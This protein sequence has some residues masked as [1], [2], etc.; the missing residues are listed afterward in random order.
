MRLHRLISKTDGLRTLFQRR[1][2]AQRL[3]VPR[4]ISLELTNACNAQCIMCPREK[5]TRRIRLIDISLVEKIAG[6]LREQKLHKLNLFWFGE[7]L[8]HPQ[9]VD[10]MRFLRKTLPSTKINLSTNGQLLTGTLAMGV[11]TSGIDTLNIDIDGYEKETYEAVRKKLNFER[12]ERNLVEFMKLREGMR[13]RRPWVSTTIIEMEPT[14]NEIVPFRK[15][16]R[17]VVDEVHVTKYN[18]WCTNVDDRN[19]RTQKEGADS[20]GFTFPCENLWKELVISS[21]GKAVACCL[22]FD[23]ATV[24]GDVT[25]QSIG[26]IWRSEPLNAIREAFMSGRQDEIPLCRGCNAHI[27]QEDSLW[28]NLWRRDGKPSNLR[29]VRGRAEDPAAE[30]ADPAVLSEARTAIMSR[31]DR[32]PLGFLSKKRGALS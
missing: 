26:E 12:V 1:V 15:R 7:S 23:A 18:T 13:L 8:L 9:C 30:E 31:K 27:F 20:P 32:D 24:V 5:M 16:W 25:V 2:L 11:L 22:D 6:E 10:I 19:I 4:L 21:D 14:K 3:K 29:G 17:R 28:A